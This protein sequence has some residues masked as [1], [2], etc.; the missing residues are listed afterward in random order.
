[1]TVDPL[2]ELLSN[3]SVDIV[4]GQLGEDAHMVGASALVLDG[5]F[6]TSMV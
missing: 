2:I 5:I 4:A 6:K 3:L 1:L